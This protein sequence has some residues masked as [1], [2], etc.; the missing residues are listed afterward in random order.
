[1][2]YTLLSAYD[3]LHKS[4]GYDGVLNYKVVQESLKQ[5]DKLLERAEKNYNKN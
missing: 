5:G 2:N 4:L 1:M 3:L